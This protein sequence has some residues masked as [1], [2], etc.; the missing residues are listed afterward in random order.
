MTGAEKTKDQGPRQAILIIHGIGEQQPNETLRRFVDGLIG[1][2][3]CVDGLIGK[4]QCFVKPDRISDTLELYRLSAPRTPSQQIRTDFYELY[5]AH[6]MGDT[7]WGHV[8]AWLRVLLLR[9]RSEVPARLRTAWTLAWL[10]LIVAA[11]GTAIYWPGAT[12]AAAYGVFGAAVVW[13]VRAAAGS[14]GLHYA[15]D[16]A[17]YL[18][19]TAPNVKVRHAIRRS[20]L[21]V[22]RGLHSNPYHSTQHY[23]RIVVVGHSLGS[24]IA[25]DALKYLWQEWHS[26]P[27]DV[28]DK[29]DLEQPVWRKMRDRINTRRAETDKDYRS[30]QREL[31]DEQRRLG[32]KWKITD[33]VT[34]GSPL[35]HAEFLLARDRRDL[36]SR[37]MDR[38]LPTCPPQPEDFRD[39]GL[40]CKT[41]RFEGHDHDVLV[42]HHAGLFACTRWT[43]L[44]F[45]N[46]IIG[47]PLKPQ[48]GS[49][50]KDVELRDPPKGLFGGSW[51]TSHLHY[52][53]RAP[54][55][56][57][58][59]LREALDLTYSG[60]SLR[61]TCPDR[62]NVVE[63][64]RRSPV[65]GEE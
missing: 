33:F 30:L 22:L 34:L 44:Y 16:A 60:H 9:R 8:T 52:W 37:K 20:A 47:G 50:I 58:A 55:S 21:E 61:E 4:D 28:C 45:T 46:D 2:D 24:V 18:S 32:I 19:A 23:D 43:N 29:T 57:L 56:A 51:P 62:E 64:A 11:I 5:W 25:Y 48:L 14:F 65:T 35:A 36:C 63:A 53:H 42:L 49:Q 59:S 1:K 13:I 17:R 15:G 38:E 54:E 12:T 41:A 39:A 40:L 10:M 26:Y 7:T 6:Q 3:Q 27:G 31:W